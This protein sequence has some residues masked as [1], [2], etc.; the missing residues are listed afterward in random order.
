MLQKHANKQKRK[1]LQ[2][3]KSYVNISIE[4]TKS[5]GNRT[6]LSNLKFQKHIS[7]GD[8]LVIDEQA[9]LKAQKDIK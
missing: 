3:N 5:S 8:G 7:F 4:Q 2:K 9:G 6:S 1:H